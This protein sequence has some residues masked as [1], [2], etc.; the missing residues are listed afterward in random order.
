MT[1]TVSLSSLADHGKAGSSW[2]PSRVKDIQ[3][4]L[5]NNP[6]LLAETEGTRALAEAEA[7]ILRYLVSPSAAR[8]PMALWA[9]ATHQ[10]DNFDSFPSF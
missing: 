8:F 6:A 5:Q 1:S 3:A 9:I 2:E 4:E 7:F 10:A